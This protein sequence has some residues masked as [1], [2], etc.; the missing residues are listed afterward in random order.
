MKR[1]GSAAFGLLAFLFLASCSHDVR[2]A[3]PVPVSEATREA[4]ASYSEIGRRHN[5]ELERFYFSRTGRSA[6]SESYKAMS[7][8]P[9]Y[10][11]VECLYFGS[12]DAGISAGRNAGG[13]TVVE[14]LAEKQLVSQAAAELLV[15]I[16]RLLRNPL[17]T[18]ELM[19][20]AI[21]E[22]QDVAVSTLEGT[23]LDQVMSYAETAKA[24]LEFWSE[25]L[26]EL[27]DQNE[28]WS[29]QQWWD[30]NKHKI[31]MMAVSDAAGAAVGAILGASIGSSV[32]GVGA[33]PGAGV[34][35]VICGAASSI[36]GFKEDKFCVVIPWEQ[37]NS[38]VVV[39]R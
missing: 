20:Q 14:A 24:S 30:T 7:L 26:G 6:G 37:L 10:G 3:S 8:E 11:R 25:N 2:I 12:M 29:I 32:G 17:A 16:E 31:A 4:V 1:L 34:G 21:L 39:A 9:V 35:A 23:E 38:S 15:R 22:V 19:N 28:G 5:L 18:R 36:Q 27:A 33:G 13:S